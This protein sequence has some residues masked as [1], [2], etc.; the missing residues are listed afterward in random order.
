M[1]PCADA[2]ILFCLLVITCCTLAVAQIPVNCCLSIRD[3]KIHKSIVTAYQRQI[4]GQGCNIDA[5]IFV[6]KGGKNL[7]APTDKKWVKALM[8]YVNRCKKVNF[9]TKY[10]GARNTAN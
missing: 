7:C 10:C 6:T 3:T 5:V 4:A 2:K 9:T 1:T 8:R